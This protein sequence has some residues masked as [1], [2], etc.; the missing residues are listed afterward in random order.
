YISDRGSHTDTPVSVKDVVSDGTFAKLSCVERLKGFHRLLHF[1]NTTA[2]AQLPRRVGK[3]R[4]IVGAHHSSRYIDH[5]RTSAR[6][7]EPKSCAGLAAR[8]RALVLTL[9]WG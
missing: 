3:I 1:E 2:G 9:S 4:G 5:I 6:R 7:P 8:M